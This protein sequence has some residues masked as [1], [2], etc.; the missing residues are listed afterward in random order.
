MKVPFRTS[1][2]LA[3]AA[4]LG[5]ATAAPSPAEAAPGQAK[6]YVAKQKIHRDAATGQLRLPTPEET[7]ELVATLEQLT[8]RSSEGLASHEGLN[9]AQVVALDGRFAGVVLSKPRE[10]GS[11]ETHCVWTFEQAAAFLGLAP[12]GEAAA[13]TDN[14]R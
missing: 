7:A 6:K 3:A 9:G 10:D 13:G 8:N 1:L 4:L 12:E 5:V 14:T 11:F 2:A